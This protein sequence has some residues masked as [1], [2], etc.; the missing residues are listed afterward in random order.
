MTPPNPQKSL[1]AI[2][3]LASLRAFPRQGVSGADAASERLR[4]RD[5]YE[6]VV[7]EIHIADSEDKGQSRTVR[8]L[9]DDLEMWI[10]LA[11]L[12]ENDNLEK[13]VKATQEALRISKDKAEEAEN[14]RLLNNL[15]VLRHLEGNSVEARGIYEEALTHGALGGEGL[16]TTMLY[17]LARCYEDLGEVAMA[18]EAYDK[19]LVRHPEY[20]DGGFPCMIL[21]HMLTRIF[22]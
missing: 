12:W 10:E 20:I 14:P 11:Q 18:Q 3:I 5:L 17:N 21:L 6:R 19:L 13:T 4:A 15:A 1:E 22:S 9:G 7:K 16:S 2:I 8:N